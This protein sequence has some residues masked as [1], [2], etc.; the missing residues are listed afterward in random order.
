MAPDKR[1]PAQVPVT[2]LTDDT[3][4]VVVDHVG[5]PGHELGWTPDGKRFMMMNNREQRRRR[6]RRLLAPDTSWGGAGAVGGGP[7]CR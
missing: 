6:R 4:E 1:L 3:W 2:R 5:S 7:A